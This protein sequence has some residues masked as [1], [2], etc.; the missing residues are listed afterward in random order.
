MLKALKSYDSLLDTDYTVLLI[1]CWRDNYKWY[2]IYLFFPESLSLT[3]DGDLRNIPYTS[4][5]QYCCKLHGHG[6]NQSVTDKKFFI[7]FDWPLLLLWIMTYW[8]IYYSVQYCII[9]AHCHGLP[10]WYCKSCSTVVH[11]DDDWWHRTVLLHHVRVQQ[12][13]TTLNMTECTGICAPTPKKGRR[14]T[15]G[16][17]CTVT[18]TVNSKESVISVQYKNADRWLELNLCQWKGSSVISFH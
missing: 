13:S 17:K 5:T 3:L 9:S 16:V 6:I 18:G 15:V 4:D 12:F 11:N 10:Y 7:N 1:K 14:T 8:F 2:C